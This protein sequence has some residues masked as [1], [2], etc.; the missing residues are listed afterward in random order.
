MPATALLRGANRCTKVC[1]L[2]AFVDRKRVPVQ[3]KRSGKVY[4][5]I[6]WSQE[7]D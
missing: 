5:S 2:S 6:L 1:V 7:A 3:E 4:M